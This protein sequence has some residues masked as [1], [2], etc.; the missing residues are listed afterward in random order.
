MARRFQSRRPAFRAS[1]ESPN[2]LLDRYSPSPSS[3]PIRYGYPGQGITAVVPR[4]SRAVDWINPPASPGPIRYG[5]PERMP[6]PIPYGP[7]GPIRYG[8]LGQDVTAAI[9]PIPYGN[10]PPERLRAAGGSWQDQPP[11]TSRLA[12]ILQA[13]KRPRERRGGIRAA[14]PR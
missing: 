8:T 4:E 11:G 6:A 7:A 12:A 14:V 5:N 1:T 9:R 2:R 3:G 10:P 13:L